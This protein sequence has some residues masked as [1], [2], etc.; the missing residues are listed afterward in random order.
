MTKVMIPG[1]FDPFTLGHLDIVVRCSKIFDEIIVVVGNNSQK[2]YLLSAESRVKY[3]EDATKN[4]KNVKCVLWDGLIADFAVANGIKIIVK[5]IRNQVDV[6]Y[7]N[8][9][10][11]VNRSIADTK[12]NAVLET[13]YLASLPEYSHISSSVVRKL[14]SLDLSVNSYVHN[15]ELLKKLC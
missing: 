5:G 14:L 15:E 11:F 8:E 13:F 2:K 1:S 6:E 9:M 12:N 3:I 7:E 4:F 10:T